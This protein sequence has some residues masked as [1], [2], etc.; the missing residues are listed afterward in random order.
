MMPQDVDLLPVGHTDS[1]R[2]SARVDYAIR[3]AAEM[4]AAPG[5]P[6]K[7]ESLAKSQG[8]SVSFLETILGDLRRAG[9]VLSQRGRDGGHRLARDAADISVAD[10]VRA[11]TGNL[12]D[13][14]GNRPEDMAYSGAAA[15][16][17]DV[18]VAARSAYRNVL[19]S[20]T[21]ADMVAGTFSADVVE[22]IERPDSW[23][24]HGLGE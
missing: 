4:A 5:K 20:V 17:T 14:Y 7:A 13:I 11:E 9:L 12:F 22:L 2:V 18:W 19:E 21:L 1:M 6:H 8:I 24:S 10:V 23:N 15:N 3:A 16:L